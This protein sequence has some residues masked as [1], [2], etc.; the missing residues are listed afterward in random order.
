M[1]NAV[2]R[3]RLVL[4][5]V[6]GLMAVIGIFPG[7]LLRLLG[8][9]SVNADNDTMIMI[10]VYYVAVFMLF[11]VWMFLLVLERRMRDENG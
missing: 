7:I 9:D 3:I 1:A 2:R 10:A 6:I 5:V 11:L 4:L 8:V